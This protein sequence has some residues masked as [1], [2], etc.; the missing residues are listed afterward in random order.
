ITSFKMYSTSDTNLRS[1]MKS[2]AKKFKK[3][4]EFEE[5]M[6]INDGGKEVEF[7]VKSGKND[8]IKELIMFVEGSGE[9][10]SVVFQLTL[11]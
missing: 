4:K 6:R 7:L 8:E 5:L 3:S 2:I 10:E 9:N 1:E 11:S